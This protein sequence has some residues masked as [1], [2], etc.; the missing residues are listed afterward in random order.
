M[1]T[2]ACKAK[3]PAT[4]WKHGS[5]YVIPLTPAGVYGNALA[6]TAE[7]ASGEKNLKDYET[8][9]F[10]T[11][12]VRFLAYFPETRDSEEA[13][14]FLKLTENGDEARYEKIKESVSKSK[15]VLDF[16]KAYVKEHGL[17]H[18]VA[19]SVA[20][21]KEFGVSDVRYYQMLNNNPE[22]MY[23][24]RQIR[25]AAKVSDE[26]EDFITDRQ[27]ETEINQAAIRHL[28]GVKAAKKVS[29][30]YRSARQVNQAFDAWESE[31]E[32]DRLR[33]ADRSRVYVD[34]TAE[35]KAEREYYTP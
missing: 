22:V 2:S 26:K 30:P 3:N 23:A 9:D 16:D 35:A 18:N 11:K 12:L 1:T 33:A 28:Y 14:T 8:K 27:K 31:L 6:L 5:A 4:C 24:R 13:H 34:Q 25:E 10:A 20:I 7:I 32:S 29:Q 15:K 17:G 19:K 21:N